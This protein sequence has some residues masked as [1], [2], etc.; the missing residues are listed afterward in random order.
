MNF[1]SV[2]EIALVQCLELALVKWLQLVNQL[3]EGGYGNITLTILIYNTPLSRRML[4]S[5]KIK[6]SY[7]RMN[8][9]HY[10]INH[11]TKYWSGFHHSISQSIFHFSSPPNTTPLKQ[12]WVEGLDPNVRAWLQRP[13]E[14]G[15]NPCL[16]EIFEHYWGSGSLLLLDWLQKP[17]AYC[18]NTKWYNLTRCK[19]KRK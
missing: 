5:M 13:I 12:I 18:F 10:E 11:T 19:S 7:F 14:E 4:C 9:L 3:L 15:P 16:C 8:L 2:L 6:S 1:T 17:R